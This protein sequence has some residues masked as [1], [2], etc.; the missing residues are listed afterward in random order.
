MVVRKRSQYENA[1]VGNAGLN[2][3]AWQLSRR[4]WHALPTIRN[5]RGS[6]LYVT[7]GDETIFFGVQ[8]KALSRRSPV[9]LSKNG[10]ALRSDW[11]VITINACTASPICFILRNEEV[12]ALAVVDKNGA[13]GRWLDPRAYDRDEY[14]EAWDRLGDPNATLPL[15]SSQAPDEQNGVRRPKTQSLCGQAW[16]IFDQ[17]SEA[18][19]KPAAIAEALERA[20]AQGLNEGNVRTEFYR[21]RKFNG[22]KDRTPRRKFESVSSTAESAIA[23]M[24]R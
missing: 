11:W 7:N 5:A 16:A 13:G 23:A 14:R 24:A 21:W 10:D 22:F 3:T 8:S 6:D 18:Q 20:R 4:G 9:P 12:R 17:I 2:F 1:M 19:G 15:S